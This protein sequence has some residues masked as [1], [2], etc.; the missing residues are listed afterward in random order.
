M[1]A[2]G[3]AERLFPHKLREDPLLLDDLRREIADALVVQ[4]DR[5]ELERLLLRLAVGA[6]TDRLYVSFPR[7]ESSEARARVPSFYALDVMRAVTGRVPDH[8]TLERE[9]ASE[10]DASLAWPAPAQADDAIDEFEHDLS[11]LRSLMHRGGD[12]KGRAHYLLRLNDCLR[13][14]VTERWARAKRSWS[15]VRRSR[16]GHGPN[17]SVS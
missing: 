2:P 14:S 16:A 7:I 3:L 10:A 11:V 1:F 6:A 4:N 8:Q 5:A 9:A 15:H 12:V 17:A 13:R